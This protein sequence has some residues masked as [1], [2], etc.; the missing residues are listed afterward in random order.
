MSHVQVASGLSAALQNSTPS[1]SYIATL[2]ATLVAVCIAIVVVVA[3]TLKRMSHSKSC[4]QD[5]C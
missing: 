4:T 3:F 2:G 1:R 5:Q